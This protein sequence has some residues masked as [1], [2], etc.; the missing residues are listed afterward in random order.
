MLVDLAHY[1]PGITF[2]IARIEMVANT[3]TPFHSSPTAPTWPGSCWSDW[4]TWR[5]F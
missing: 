1:A 3:G 5:G 4:P 2:H